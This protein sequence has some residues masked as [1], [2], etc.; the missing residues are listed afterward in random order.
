MFLSCS[1]IRSAITYGRLTPSAF[2]PGWAS[3]LFCPTHTA[4]L[5]LFR[6]LFLHF[7]VLLHWSATYKSQSDTA[8]KALTSDPQ[9]TPATG[10]LIG[11]LFSHIG[12]TTRMD[13]IWIFR[14]NYV[15]SIKYN[16]TIGTTGMAE[17]LRGSVGLWKVPCLQPWLQS[18]SL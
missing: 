15:D 12:L 16:L 9:L 1:Y 4:K 11:D 18:D 17:H 2:R 3:C 14:H 7:F 5:V 10:C 6:I 8:D 13:R